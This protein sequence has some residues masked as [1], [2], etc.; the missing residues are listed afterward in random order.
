MTATSSLPRIIAELRDIVRQHLLTEKWLLAPSLRVGHQWLELLTRSGQAAINLHIKTL[1]GLAHELAVPALAR[2]NQC[3]L[4]GRGGALVMDAILGR[5]R[6]DGLVY[7]H[8][9]AHTVGLSEA[10]YRSI[11]DLRLAGLDPARL[12]SE[13]FEDP[14]KGLDL[15][16]VMTAYLEQLQANRLVDYPDILRL[17]RQRLRDDPSALGNDIL[18]LVPGDAE[19][20]ALERDLLDAMPKVILRV[21]EPADAA[22]DPAP[23]RTDVDLLRWLHSPGSAPAPPRDGTVGMFRAVGEV[24]EVREVLRRCL[25]HDIPLDQVEILHTDTTAYVPLIYEVFQALPHSDGEPEGEPPVTFAE[26]IPCRFG[27][28]GRALA[29]WLSWLR[30]DCAQETLVGM[31]REGLLT[32]LGQDHPSY[33]RLAAALRSIGIGCGRERYLPKLDRQVARY[34]RRVEAHSTDENGDSLEFCQR[35]LDEFRALRALV[36]DLVK[37][38]P[39]LQD[40]TPTVL[41]AALTFLDKVARRV[42]ELDNYARIRLED[43]IKEVQHYLEQSVTPMAFDVW[44]WLTA[45]PSE[46]MI[47]GSGPRAGCLHVSAVT[48][49]G[50]SG[51]PHT[52]LIGLD[53]SRFP[54]ASMQDP[55][56]LDSERGRLSDGLVTS[57]NRLAEKLRGFG[58]LLAR[59]RGSVTLSY[60]CRDLQDDRDTFPSPVILDAYRI[61]SGNHEADQ[62]EFLSK[63]LRTPVSFAPDG[64][65]H[66][67]DEREWWLWR[68]CGPGQAANA[69]QLIGQRFPHIE[70]GWEARRQRDSDAFTIYDGCVVQAGADLDPTAA[71]G[72]V[73]SS[74]K[75]ETAGKCPLRYFFQH[76]LELKPPDDV[77]IDRAVW[78]DPRNSG[79]LCHEVFELFL[80]ELIVAAR[81]PVYA[82]D[83]GRLLAILDERAARYRD[84][85]PPPSDS[86]FQEQYQQLR[87]TAHIFLKE[88][89]SFC[90]RRCCR[91][92]FL[93]SS[94]GLETERPGSPLDT[95]EPVP[96]LLPGGGR[97]RVA[98]RVDRVDRLE[99]RAVQSF[100]IWDY[101]NSDWGYDRADPFRQG[102][103][104]QPFIYVSMV[105]H[106]LLE[107]VSREAS[108]TCFGFFFTG[109]RQRGGRI[110]W[111]SH[112]LEAGGA[113]LDNVCA[114]IRRGAF[115]ATDD[116]KTDCTFCDYRGIC[117]DVETVTAASRAKLA[118]ADNALLQPF[119]VLR[120]NGKEQETEPDE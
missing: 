80:S 9:S 48:A 119:L 99:N 55:L 73:L 109:L 120:P 22:A 100:A 116:W 113:I 12:Q 64:P 95:G 98:G 46:A 77:R 40:G 41:A 114:I 96:I 60:S 38:S 7:L 61:L 103:V 93:E 75:L 50:H 35:R 25:A 14:A 104:L 91:P 74:H 70:R 11:L 6:A 76:V 5:L 92:M 115:L 20:R 36:A 110:E 27:R 97:I 94:I 30:E 13:A 54:G 28:P 117:G 15:A 65:D 45:L 118:N 106:R 69:R 23:T 105:T 68:L 66:C 84:D 8:N 2:N 59:L 72:P 87:Q 57:S 102:R 63:A 33:A 10:V 24:N 67:L 39:K 53:D 111:E 1:R 49:G 42:S 32:V 108:I 47:M 79:R 78:L 62:T 19:P 37:F 34:E 17:A 4:G 58:R 16:K 81:V 56:L 29:A 83:W 51:R 107:A 86:I 52:F 101:K 90:A 3:R 85:F 26:G 82:R 88:E 43:D 44:D 18:I 21:D 31:V 112:E 71:N 89:E